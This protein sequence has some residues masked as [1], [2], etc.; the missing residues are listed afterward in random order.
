MKYT[1]R[2]WWKKAV[3]VKADALDMVHFLCR[4]YCLYILRKLEKASLIIIR[5]DL[6]Y[7][8]LEH[9]RIEHP[10]STGLACH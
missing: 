5:G 6:S 2:H 7:E 10:N 8:K 9:T 4:V 3:S 1:L